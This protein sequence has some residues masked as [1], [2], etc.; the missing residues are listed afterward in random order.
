MKKEDDKL[1]ALLW[2]YEI[3]IADQPAPQNNQNYEQLKKDLAEY[4]NDLLVGDYNKLISILYRIDIAQ[5]K[6]VA[7]LAKNAENESPGETLA[8]LIIERQLQKI[9]TRRKYRKE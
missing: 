1:K 3:V 8:R 7:E 4:L 5:E 9:E 2:S 6:A